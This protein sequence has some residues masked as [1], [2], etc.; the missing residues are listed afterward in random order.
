MVLLV[1]LAQPTGAQGAELSFRFE[2]EGPVV[3]RATDRFD[4]TLVVTRDCDLV[5]GEDSLLV[6]T[7]SSAKGFSIDGPRR[8][9]FAAGACPEEQSMVYDITVQGVEE[10]HAYLTWAFAREAFG[11]TGAPST[12]DSAMV[13]PLMKAT[14]PDDASPGSTGTVDVG[15]PGTPLLLLMVASVLRSRPRR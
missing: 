1:A 4:V 13:L 9:D 3:F 2:E 7:S 12:R 5:A 6:E 11:P 15:F 10:P 8:I 14:G